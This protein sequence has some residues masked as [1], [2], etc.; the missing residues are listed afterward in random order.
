MNL[1]DVGP[2]P[3][4]DRKDKKDTGQ[5][6]GLRIPVLPKAARMTSVALKKAGT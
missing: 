2:Q 4:A 3:E 5:I 6:T 1:P